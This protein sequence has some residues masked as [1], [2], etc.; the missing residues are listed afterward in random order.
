MQK[1]TKT[2]YITFIVLTSLWTACINNQSQD[3]QIT[4]DWYETTKQRIITEADLPAE[5]LSTGKYADTDLTEITYSH[6][7]Q[8]LKTEI[9]REDSSLTAITLYSKDG[10]FEL[11]KEICPNGQTGFEGIVYDGHFYGLSTWWHCN[12]QLSHQGIR[13]KDKKV[14]IW[15]R[16]DENGNL[17][18][19]TDYENEHL[20]DSLKTI[21]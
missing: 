16:W 11:R 18:E 12:G 15:N 19:T 13:Y 9:L 7:D 17:T 21:N 8:K 10:Q 2:T 20:I 4:D 6:H 1:M 14:G 3:N 5:T